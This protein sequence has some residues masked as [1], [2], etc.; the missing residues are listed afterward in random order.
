MEVNRIYLIIITVLCIGAFNISSAQGTENVLA[1]IGNKNLTSEEFVKR[2]ESVPRFSNQIKDAMKELKD[3]LFYTLVAEKLFALEGESLRLDT[4]E[5]IR[6]RLS[7]IRDLLIRDALYRDE[8]LSKVDVSDQKIVLE[9]AKASVTLKLKYI[10]SRD[11]KEITDL[12]NMLL[13]GVPFDTLFDARYGKDGGVFTFTAKYGDLDP[14]IEDSIYVKKPGEFTVPLLSDDL[15]LIYKIQDKKDTVYKTAQD[16]ENEFKRIKKLT[17][18]KQQNL[19]AR[20][21]LIKLLTGKKINSDG[22]VLRVI[23]NKITDVIKTLN[24]DKSTGLLTKQP[25]FPFEY[26]EFREVKNSLSSKDLDAVYVDIPGNP[27]TVRDFLYFLMDDKLSLTVFENE[28]VYKLLYDK[29][30]T[31]IE[32]R[33]ITIEGIKKGLDKTPAVTEDLQIWKDFYL[34]QAYQTILADSSK[35]TDDEAREYYNRRYKGGSG[36]LLLKIKEIFTSGIDNAGIVLEK[37]DKGENFDKLA[38]LYNERESTRGSNGEW[39][40]FPSGTNGEIGAAAAKLPVGKYYGPVANEGGYSIIL[41]VDKKVNES[42]SSDEFEV[43]KN[44]IKKDIAF[45][46]QKEFMIKNTSD[47]ALKYGVNM[48]NDLLNGVQVTNSNILIYRLFGFGGRMVAFPIT[49]PFMDWLEYFK[50]KTK[51]GL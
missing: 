40:W 46:R 28:R 25:P 37:L 17:E 21:Y 44:K 29:T 10:T 30:R 4:I 27:V 6:Y 26:R 16:V 11:R 19:L 49:T 32:N 48:N 1:K 38:E 24:T 45:S 35:V 39:D 13:N 43:M 22:K 23:G 51:E 9:M 41:L 31:M 2:F 33:L 15:W 42:F 7:Y 36:G 18:Q 12:Y 50:T 20:E 34:S 8:I 3:E 14:E 5:S 47:L